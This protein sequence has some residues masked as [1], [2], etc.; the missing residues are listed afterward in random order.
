[1]I[2][3]SR[4]VRFKIHHWSYTWICLASMLGKSSK[5]I[6]PYM[7]VFFNGDESHRIESVKKRSSYKQIQV[8]STQYV[9][10]SNV[11]SIIQSFYGRRGVSQQPVVWIN[12]VTLHNRS[13]SVDGA[14]S[15]G[16]RWNMMLQTQELAWH[17]IFVNWWLLEL[18]GLYQIIISWHLWEK[19]FL[20][21][22]NFKTSTAFTNL[23][24]PTTIRIPPLKNPAN[25]P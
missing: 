1:M 21:A 20:G 23:N 25:S 18:H 5:I 19:H 11:F 7:M 24:N 10:F 6:F 16:L 2:V 3:F 14:S 9:V 22:W 13:H 17:V 15:R 12:G 4:R 8:P